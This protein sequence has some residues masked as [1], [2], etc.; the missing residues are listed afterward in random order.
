MEGFQ[1]TTLNQHEYLQS[2]RDRFACDFS[3][4]LTDFLFPLKPENQSGMLA[5]TCNPA[6][7][8]IRQD[9]EPETAKGPPASWSQPGL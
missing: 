4:I 7:G 1:P 6:L 3:K 5:Q 9:G 8:R 2:P